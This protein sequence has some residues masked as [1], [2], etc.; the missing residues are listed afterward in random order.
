MKNKLQ[1]LYLKAKP[2][3]FLLLT[4]IGTNFGVIKRVSE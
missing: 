2:Y 4:F 3:A 1:K